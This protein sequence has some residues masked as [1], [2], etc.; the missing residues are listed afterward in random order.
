MH[1]VAIIGGGPAG[2]QAALTLGR[3]HRS[4]ALIDSGV[5]R[6]AP[7]S[8]MHN[9]V[10]NDGRPP[11][12]FRAAARE[13][14][15]S[16]PTITSDEGKVVSITGDLGA[17]AL[18]LEN[19]D[20]VD[21]ARVILATGVA[22]ALPDIPGLADAFGDAV[23]HCP[24]CHGHEFSGGRVGIIG[25]GEHT[26]RLV[27][28]LAPIAAETVVLPGDEPVAPEVAGVLAR[29]G[30][31]IRSGRI[32]EIAQEGDGV[33]ARFSDGSS[34]HFAGMFTSTAW[35][36]AAPFA[37]DLGLAMSDGGAIVVDG[38]GRTSRAGVYAAGD[39]A[40]PPGLPMPLHAV[41]AAVASGQLAGAACVQ[42]LVAEALR[43]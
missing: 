41:A 29:L 27:A 21:A 32:A 14:I 19:G 31:A 18:E 17:F 7:T 2:L 22:D 43:V 34:E 40:Q 23:A 20:R 16:Y 36:Q 11:A 38:F 12:A 37:A 13:E 15:A 6:N 35:R 25:A 3:M 10:T 24:F 4:A 42:D 9:I 33:A 30:A 8:A 39:I 5:Y 26:P 28:M 1:D